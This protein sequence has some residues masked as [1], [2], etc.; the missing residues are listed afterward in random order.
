[1]FESR[2]TSTSQPS[3]P[4]LHSFADN[5]ED[6]NS[7]AAVADSI[8]GVYGELARAASPPERSTMTA[9]SRTPEWPR[10]A[11]SISPSSTR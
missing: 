8:Y 5:D 7:I 4:T 9:A 1:M 10:S 2:G 3:G 6:G 11:V